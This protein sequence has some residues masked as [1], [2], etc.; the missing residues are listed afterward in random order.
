MKNYSVDTLRNWVEVEG[1]THR[2]VSEQLECSN[3][4]VSALCKRHGVRP[5]RRGPRSGQGHPDWAGGRIVDKSGYTRI[6]APH[7]PDS[8][9]THK[10]RLEHR[11]VMEMMLGRYLARHEVVHHRNGDKQDNRPENLE[12]FQSNAE[13]LATEL[14][15]RQPRWTAEGRERIA[16]GV[17]KAHGKFRG[18]KAPGVL[19]LP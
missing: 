14:K 5:Q 2:W 3:Q 13:H 15:G 4:H 19:A 7:H 9:P 12:L 18:W 11:L 6:Y 16:A 1:R 8:N 17:R 10:Y